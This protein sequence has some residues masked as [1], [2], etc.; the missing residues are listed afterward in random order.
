VA[1]AAPE[2]ALAA[3]E[4]AEYAPDAG[5]AS[6]ACR[7]HLHTILSLAY[8]PALFERA[9]ELL[10]DVAAKDGADG[11]SQATSMFKSLFQLY[12]SG[13]R[14]TI[15]QRLVVIQRLLAST[16]AIRRRLGAL[17]LESALN[18]GIFQA[19]THDFA[20]GSRSRDY[21]YWPRST[22]EIKHWFC[23]ALRLA[24]E[25]ACSESLTAEYARVAL[26]KELRWL[27]L[28]AG[29]P[30]EIASVCRAISGIRF[31]PEGWIAVRQ[32]LRLDGSHLKPGSHA[33]LKAIEAQLR[34]TNIVEQARSI[35]ASAPDY[36]TEIIESGES[37][38]DDIAARMTLMGEM[39]REVGREIAGNEPGL[40]ELLPDLLSTDG[41]LL[42]FGQG[43]AEGAASAEALWN[44]LVTGFGGIEEERRRSTVLAGYLCQVYA[45]NPKLANELLDKAVGDRVLAGWY[46]ILQCAVG[47][48][49]EGVSR[50]K[51]SLILG[52]T[53]ASTYLQ[54]KWG[55]ATDPISSTELREILRMIAE[56]P[57]GH[58][59]AIEV[60]HMRLF[61]DQ[62]KH[63]A[64]AP[65]LIEVGRDLVRRCPFDRS[66][67]RLDYTLGEIARTC[68]KWPEGVVAVKQVCRNLKDAI[69][70]FRTFA[71]AFRRLLEGLLSAQPAAALD[72]LCGGGEDDLANGM[73]I[74]QGAMNRADVIAAIPEDELVQWCDEDPAARYPAFGGV[75]AFS[76]RSPETGKKC[77][78]ALA[79]RMLRNAPDPGAVLKQFVL[80]FMSEGGWGDSQIVAGRENAQLLDQLGEF[81]GLEAAL[82]EEKVRVQEMIRAEEELQAGFHTQRY[83]QFE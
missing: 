72:G 65:E 20:F 55:R 83:E 30:E 12:L 18:A 66:W 4:S 13:T 3:L 73:R 25:V 52:T 64:T 60:L 63:G 26:A 41:D 51:R 17:A 42:P 68:F 8:E 53:P 34:P 33:H 74:L 29:I 50:L 28:R 70:E 11:R 54:L 21:G 61:S 48:D 62:E 81:D 38:P 10:V 44:R 7:Q 14:S 31:W 16:D 37:L 19:A 1:P 22:D 79:L 15:E 2:D 24:Q 71:P 56:M 40:A 80:R 67:E 77:W 49:S 76:E 27:W 46:P 47:V 5:R 32:T 43:L 82:A 57:S 59:V 23:S 6:E 58:E 36:G 39:A 69:V 35:I 45:T 78:T 9:A 75:V